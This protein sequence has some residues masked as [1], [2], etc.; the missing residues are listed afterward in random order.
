MITV[1][2]LFFLSFFF[3]LPA[4]YV[5]FSAHVDYEQISEFV[6]VLKP[7]QVV[8]LS[9]ARFGFLLLLLLLCTTLSYTLENRRSTSYS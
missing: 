6:R 3:L 7:P 5:S 8:S 1:L 9:F 4:D 2:G